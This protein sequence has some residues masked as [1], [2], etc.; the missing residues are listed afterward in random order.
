MTVF[1]TNLI[2]LIKFFLIKINYLILLYIIITIIIAFLEAKNYFKKKLANKAYIAPIYEKNYYNFSTYYGFQFNLLRFN[3]LYNKVQYINSNKIIQLFKFFKTIVYFLFNII[4]FNFYVILTILH[5][6]KKPLPLNL[7]LI[8]FNLNDTRKIIFVFNIWRVNPGEDYFTKWL[9]TIWT[10][11]F[12]FRDKKHFLY[13]KSQTDE[14]F[15]MFNENYFMYYVK[16]VLGNKVFT[17]YVTYDVLANKRGAY[18]TTEHTAKL[19]EYFNREP[20]IEKIEY[21]KTS[22]LLELPDQKVTFVD[23]SNTLPL[24]EIAL[25]FGLHNN[26]KIPENIDPNIK[27]KFELF[28]YKY[29]SQRYNGCT[30]KESQEILDM[31][32]T[33]K[34]KMYQVPNN[35]KGSE[36]LIE[37]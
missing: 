3:F 19:R 7:Q 4:I 22:T 27:R 37:N 13:L 5:I 31:F 15:N 11:P 17:H 29:S 35:V 14:S 1:K 9:K 8:V 12:L 16:H 24:T 6:Y 25:L 2:Y 20:L 10:K 32:L 26:S 21:L 23:K 36:F 28:N 18:L 34:A 33:I 30:K